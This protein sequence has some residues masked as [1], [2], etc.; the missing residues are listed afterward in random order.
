[1]SLVPY[2]RIEDADATFVARPAVLRDAPS[3]LLRITGRVRL[4]PSL[5]RGRRATAGKAIKKISL[6]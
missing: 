2:R 1:M 5:P 6:I 4:L 3:M